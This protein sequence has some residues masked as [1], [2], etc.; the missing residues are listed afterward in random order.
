MVQ[1]IY[2]KIGTKT[3]V[4]SMILQLIEK[5]ESKAGTQQNLAKLFN[6]R[7]NRFADY[8]AGRRTPDDELIGQ[9]AEYVGLDPIETILQ[10]KLE[11]ADKEKATLWQE[12]LNKW[13]PHGDSNPGYRRERAMSIL[14][15]I[16]Q[17]IQHIN[18]TIGRKVGITL[19]NSNVRM[20]KQLAYMINRNTLTY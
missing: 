12:W 11:T 14:G 15:K 2:T 8:K 7:Y 18:K 5:A 3:R 4:N 20:P 17:L 10:C 1:S 13:R 19:G 6:I 9:L 16:W